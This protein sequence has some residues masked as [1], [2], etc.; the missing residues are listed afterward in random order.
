MNQIDD[1]DKLP[2]AMTLVICLILALLMI[3]VSQ[4]E[5]YPAEI[6]RKQAVRA[7]IGEASNQG[8]EGMMAVACALRNR[9]TLKG[10][11]GFNAPHV[12]KE[13]AWVWRQ[14][15]RAWEESGSNDITS[16]ATHW[17]NVGREGENYWTR[18]LQKTVK[19]GDHQFYKER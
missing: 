14:A 10:V 2:E 9:G 18:A 4:K 19:I 3:F 7:I 8:Y 6:P 1:N 12:D 5:A 16:G 13:P 11:Y 17:H 15:E